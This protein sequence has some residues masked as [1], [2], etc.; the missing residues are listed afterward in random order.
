MTKTKT[1]I[2]LRDWTDVNACNIVTTK[3]FLSCVWQ[4]LTGVNEIVTMDLNLQSNPLGNF[5]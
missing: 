4:S 5:L 1:I 2:K 3:T